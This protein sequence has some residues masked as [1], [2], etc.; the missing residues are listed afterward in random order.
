MDSVGASQD[1]F[2]TA[3][4]EEETQK[5]EGAAAAKVNDTKPIVTS[6]AKDHPVTNPVAAPSSAKPTTT[7]TI[8]AATEKSQA[9]A[10]TTS[11]TP[12]TSSFNA[13]SYNSNGTNNNNTIQQSTL[14]RINT[15]PTLLP[16]RSSLKK[17]DNLPTPPTRRSSL[18]K[19]IAS[20]TER[21]SVVSQQSSRKSTVTFGNAEVQHF[22]VV[23]PTNEDEEVTPKAGHAKKEV[24]GSLVGNGAGDIGTG[25]TRDIK[26]EKHVKD[27]SDSKDVRPHAITMQLP[28]QPKQNTGNQIPGSENHVQSNAKSQKLPENKNIIKDTDKEKENEDDVLR[29]SQAARYAPHRRKT[30]IFT[31]PIENGKFVMEVPVSKRVLEG[32]MFDGTSEHGEE[33]T[34][35]RYTAITCKAS[36]FADQ[37]YT[38]R[39]KIYG[40][41]TKIAVVITMYNESDKLLCKS[42]RAVMK[43]ISYLCSGHVPN[44]YPDYWKNIVVVIVA[45]G[46]QK[47]D[48]NV[49][50][51]MSVQGCY[52]DNLEKST[53][54]GDKVQAHMFEFTTQISIDKTLTLTG[55]VFDDHEHTRLVPCQVIFLIKQQNSKKINSHRWFFDGICKILN[56]NICIL[57][58]V[59][60]KPRKKSFYHLYDAFEHNPHVGGACG[61]IV[62]QIGARGGKLLNP[63]VA[64][65]NF[66][67]KMSNIL[68]KPLESVFGY[69]QVLPGAFS[70]YRFE[71]VQGEPLDIY[72]R[73]DLTENSPDQVSIQEANIAEDRILCFEVVLKKDKNWVL[74]Y[75]KS[76]AA[77]TDVPSRLDDFIGQRRRWLN[78]SFFV[79]LYAT[80]NWMRIFQ[81]AHTRM[82]K[83]L[84]LFEFLYNGLNL[85]FTWFGLGNFYLS[86]YYLFNISSNPACIYG[87]VESP[88]IDPFYPNGA[89]A[90]AVI[91]DTSINEYNA[92]ANS[93][94]SFGEY[95]SHDSTFRDIVI[96]VLST[97]GV[98]ALSSFLHM[99]PFHVFTCSIQYILMLPTFVNILNVYAFC[100]LHDISWG[101]KG[102]NLPSTAPAVVFQKQKDGSQ[103]AL[104]EIPYEPTDVNEQWEEFNRKLEVASNTYMLRKDDS[105]PNANTQR[106][107]WYLVGWYME[108]IRQSGKR[109][110]FDKA[111]KFASPDRK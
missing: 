24:G 16:I 18:R 11:A 26:Y 96:S 34:K 60:T 32:V 52:M 14:T 22:D 110:P 44:W 68:D 102:D 65:Q 21:D 49:L 101:T 31:I 13:I 58:D 55:Q 88:A 57:L 79:A 99:E 91:Q 19:V 30:S 43:N 40:R 64:V 2:T 9:N 53:V 108:F 67:Y 107:A 42:L 51:A 77:E 1:S 37:G 45:D 97:Y 17:I 104:V 89:D 111:W 25:T 46:R 94:G 71:A 73:G 23:S 75:V 7:T 74:A 63:L 47:I 61:E 56:P 85:L 109:N 90:F 36:E 106:E 66:E 41:E 3:P 20:D 70:A 81:S 103:F 78:G 35:L 39:P 54:N 76:A 87:A 82:R 62:A 100:N 84:L 93:G 69:I 5:H 92:A 50:I 59:G 33:F 6:A 48:P 38:L 29:E 10:I 105:T 28:Q 12:P 80:M 98:Y 27:V 8:A 86:L 72:F 15:P 95:A 83:W 4:D